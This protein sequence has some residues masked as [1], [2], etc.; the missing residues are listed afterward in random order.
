MRWPRN[1]T[2]APP[3]TVRSGAILHPGGSG[4]RLI[5]FREEFS[6]GIRVITERES[7]EEEEECS[8]RRRRS[9]R[10]Y[11]RCTERESAV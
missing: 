7:E 6:K 10:T 2:I 3:N 9:R 1:I 11:L 4:S 8:R 5:P